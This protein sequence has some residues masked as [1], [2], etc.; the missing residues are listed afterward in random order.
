MYADFSLDHHMML[1]LHRPCKRTEEWL[2]VTA[3][4]FG[5][6]SLDAN[7]CT[8][9]LIV[10][11]SLSRGLKDSRSAGERRCTARFHSGLTGLRSFVLY[12]TL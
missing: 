1:E 3:S 11:T 4:A 9:C 10:Q 12:D 2:Q 7:V 5:L 6:C 8:G